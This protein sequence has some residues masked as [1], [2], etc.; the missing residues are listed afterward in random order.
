MRQLKISNYV[1]FVGLTTHKEVASYLAASNIYVSTC[2]LDSTSVSLLEAMACGLAP[3]V[4]DIAGNR[5]WIRNGVNGFLFPPKN[6]RAL[7]ERIIRLVE[8]E[9]LRQEFGERCIQLVKQKARW[10]NCVSKMEAVYQSILHQNNYAPR[11]S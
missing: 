11:A 10:E 8:D 7:A 2:F 1:R 9:N 6:P 5:E 4:T 3:V